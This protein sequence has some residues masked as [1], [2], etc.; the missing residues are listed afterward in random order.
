MKSIKLLCAIV[1]CCL[2]TASLSVLA[3]DVPAETRKKIEAALAQAVPDMPYS[4]VSETPIKG[5]YQVTVDDGAFLFITADGNYLISGELYQNSADGL[6]NLSENERK[7]IRAEL[8]KEVDM[9]EMIVFAPEGETKAILNVFTDVDCGYC[10]KLH[11]EV[12]ELNSKGVEVRYLA[13]PRSGPVGPSYM[14]IASAWCALNPKQ[15]LTELKAGKTIETNVCDGN[16]VAK[17]FE[18]G[19]KMGVRGT[20]ALVLMDGTMIPG[21]QPAANLVEMLG[22]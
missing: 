21:Y 1:L 9:S 7:G 13:F 19:E 17:Q 8:L 6:V 12:P 15:A 18:L 5:V 4:Q 11:Q 22:L 20:P 2:G 3:A 10:R 14:K 16:P